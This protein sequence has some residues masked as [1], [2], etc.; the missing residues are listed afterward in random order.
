M[1]ANAPDLLA[2]FSGTIVEK[3]GGWSNANVETVCAKP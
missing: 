3:T 1:L 2:I